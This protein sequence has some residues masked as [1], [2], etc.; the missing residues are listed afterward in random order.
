MT[1]DRQRPS[2][3]T[4]PPPSGEAPSNDFGRFV[5][6][7]ASK[8]F[9]QLG[10]ERRRTRSERREQPASPDPEVTEPPVRSGPI[11]RRWRD[12]AGV[13]DTEYDASNDPSDEGFSDDDRGSGEPP[14]PFVERLLDENGKP[15]R[16]AIAAAIAILVVI[17]LIIV[18]IATRGNGDNGGDADVTPTATNA[19]NVLGGDEDTDDAG[20]PPATRTVTSSPDADAQ[21]PQDDEPT[22]TNEDNDDIQVGGDNQRD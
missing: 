2:R 17:I 8:S 18:F 21:R 4:T 15:K 6:S 14:V 22:A 7:S 20:T 5:S 1:D 13:P 3:S 19:T 9:R 16:E 12:A 10:R 11:G